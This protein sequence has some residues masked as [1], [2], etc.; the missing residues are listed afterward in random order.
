MC[1]KAVDNYAHALK[2]VSDGYKTQKM[3]IK[4]LNNYPSTIP[5]VPECYK[6]QEMCVRAVILVLL[7]LI[8]FSIDI[9]L[10][11]YVIKLLIIMLMY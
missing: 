4:A 8:L 6:T 1:C 9:R 10:K 7:Y 2:F 11:K 3:C 5:L